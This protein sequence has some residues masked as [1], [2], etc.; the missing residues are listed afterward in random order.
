MPAIVSHGDVEI[1]SAV[2]SV[3]LDLLPSGVEVIRAQSNRVPQPLSP[4]HCV[5]TP[6]RRERISTN[7]DTDIDIKL[8]GEIAG[9]T[10]IVESGG[11]LRAGYVL[12][13]LGLAP[14]T[15]V[16]EALAQDD[17]YSVDPAQTVA[18]GSRIYA[19]RHSVLQAVDIAYQCDVHGPNSDANA[20]AI[21]TAWRDEA[22]CR[23]MRETA[24]PIELQPLHADDPRQV[25]FI[26][27][28]SQWEDRWIVELH[29]QA[30]IDVSL[31]QQFADEVIIDLLPVDLVVVP[32][33]V[34]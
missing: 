6:L 26:N 11:T 10:L 23:R 3:L 2:R 13:G 34:P 15:V 33:I 12:F 31:D 7:I 21:A 25:P 22:L 14:R 8:I 1:L 27:A 18:P 19:G 32:V 17:T 30:N 16:I 5:L 4:D 9:T 29:V 24:G 20:I 28:E